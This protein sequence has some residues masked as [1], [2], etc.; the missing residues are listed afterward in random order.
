MEILYELAS[1]LERQGGPE[2]LQRALSTFE[3]IYEA[4]IGFRDVRAK[5]DGIR[6]RVAT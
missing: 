3:Q 6:K 2:R 5:V 4:D 1:T